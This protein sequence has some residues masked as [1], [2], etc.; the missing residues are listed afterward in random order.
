MGN[1]ILVVEDDERVTE[2]LTRFFRERGDTLDVARETEEAEALLC[3]APYSLVVADLRLSG[4]G[5]TRG[6]V[7]ACAKQTFAATRVILL[8]DNV[9]DDLRA[10][11]RRAADAFLDKPVSLSALEALVDFFFRRAS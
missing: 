11:R 6:D 3:N 5:S 4:A 9:A 8:G 2:S 7:V 1:R 10:E